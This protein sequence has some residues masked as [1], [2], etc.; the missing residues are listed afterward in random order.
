MSATHYPAGTHLSTWT[1][2]LCLQ[3]ITAGLSVRVAIQVCRKLLLASTVST[4]A[5]AA[6]TPP[7]WANS[8]VDASVSVSLPLILEVSSQVLLVQ[9]PLADQAVVDHLVGAVQ[10]RSN[11]ATGYQVWLRSHN[12]G[13][14]TST[15]ANQTYRVPYQLN[16]NNTP[17]PALQAV[18]VLVEQTHANSPNLLACATTN[19]CQRSLSVNVA[20]DV[21]APRPAGL[22]TDTLIIEI[23]QP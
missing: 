5:L 9:I 22:Y 23:R 16:Y 11:S 2:Q 4:T 6:T 20:T 18:P 3:L 1:K 10:I 21:S 8:S 15:Q 7:S 17:V 14:L 13:F 12:T 19:G